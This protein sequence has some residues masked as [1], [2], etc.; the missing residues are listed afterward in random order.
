[1]TSRWRMSRCTAKKGK[2]ISGTGNDVNKGAATWKQVASGGA[3]GRM[4][5][6]EGSEQDARPG[7]R[8]LAPCR[9]VWFHYRRHK[10]F[11]QRRES[12]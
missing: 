3:Q 10:G 9:G 1:M 8:G 4:E 5:M 7:V 11:R 6:P 2:G 12:P